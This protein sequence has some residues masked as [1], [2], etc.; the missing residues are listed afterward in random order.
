MDTCLSTSIPVAREPHLKQVGGTV[1]WILPRP[2][3]SVQVRGGERGGEPPGG[4]PEQAGTVRDIFPR[5]QRR[6]AALTGLPAS[7]E[8]GKAGRLS[9]HDGGQNRAR[10]A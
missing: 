3:V 10:E 2:L 5:I 6:L 7:G 1:H 9:V 4:E 8:G